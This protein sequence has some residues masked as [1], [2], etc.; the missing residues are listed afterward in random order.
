MA[1]RHLRGVAVLVG[2]IAG[3][4][5]SVGTINE[6]LLFDGRRDAVLRPYEEALTQWRASRMVPAAHARELTSISAGRDSSD[7]AALVQG[8]RGSWEERG[9]WEE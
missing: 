6:R 7:T 1:Q 3:D 2:R 8:R 5:V 9:T 4:R